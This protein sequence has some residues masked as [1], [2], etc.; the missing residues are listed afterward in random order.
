MIGGRVENNRKGEVE[1]SKISFLDAGK[2]KEAKQQ[3]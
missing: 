1:T 3:H 2:N